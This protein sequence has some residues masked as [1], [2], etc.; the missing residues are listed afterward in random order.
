MVR[1]FAGKRILCNQ[2][3]GAPR[4]ASEGLRDRER[5]GEKALKPAGARD[6]AAIVRAQFLD[7]KQRDDFL[8]LF[9]MR[10][11]LANLFG[12]TVMLISDNDRIEQDR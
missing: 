12:D 3:D 4:L 5:L 1:P 9:V 10:D 2:R 7:P 6:N 11:C 8:Q